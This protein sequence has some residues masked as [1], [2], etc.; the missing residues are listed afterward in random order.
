M[1]CEN[2]TKYDDCRAGAGLTWPCGAYQPKTVTNADRIR[3]MTDK[4]LAEFIDKCEAA[5]L[6]EKLYSLQDVQS[7]VCRH[8]NYPHGTAPQRQYAGGT[9]RRADGIVRRETLW[10]Q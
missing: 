4:E 2:C 6:G 10:L 5:G 7:A 3:R 8:A 9:D 1:K